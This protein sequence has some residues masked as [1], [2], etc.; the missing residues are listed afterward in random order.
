M[1][2]SETFYALLLTTIGGCV[3]AMLKYCY[4]SKCSSI[5]FC[6]IKIVGDINAEVK[7]DLENKEETSEKNVV[8]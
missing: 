1:E 3:L 5:D 8:K 2:L 4:K 6:C 7:E